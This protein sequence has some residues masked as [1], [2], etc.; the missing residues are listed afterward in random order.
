MIVPTLR[1][2][3]YYAVAI[4]PLA[5]MYILGDSATGSAIVLGSVLILIAV[6]DAAWAHRYLR[7]INISLPVTARMTK[8]RQGSLEISLHNASMKARRLRLGLA[9]P[10]EI[11]S[12]PGRPP[13]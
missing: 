8:D 5:L 6:I 11:M 1:L 10:G 4:P 3:I 9:L 12:P 13:R 7:G 2:L